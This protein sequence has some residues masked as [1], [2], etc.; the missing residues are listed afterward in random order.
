M[1]AGC[2]A[3]RVTA[4]LRYFAALA[5]AGVL[6]GCSAPQPPA[7]GDVEIMA[8]VVVPQRPGPA[9]T[10]VDFKQ[11]P[12]WAAEKHADAVAPFLA[13][14]GRMVGQSLGGTGEAARRAGAG[15]S[16]GAACAAAAA[17]P[18]GD[19][20]A[21]RAFFERYMQPWIASADGSA[22]GQFTGYYEPQL[23]GSSKRG[24]IYQTPLLRK[25][26]SQNLPGHNLPSRAQIVAGALAKQHLE[27]V[28][29]SDPIDA[30][31][32]EIQGAGRIHMT[33]GRDIRVSYDGQNGHGYFPIGRLLVERGE[34]ALPD[35]SLQSIRAWLIAHPKQAREV[36]NHNPSYV[37]FRE[38]PNTDPNRGPPGA[39]GAA[40]TPLR[41][42]AVDKS[43]VPMGTPVWIE[44]TDPV[45]AKP[46]RQLMMAQDV[47]GAIKG[48]V[49]AD[50]FF[51][52]G[53]PA[54][55]RAGLMNKPGAAY[56]LLPRDLGT[57]V[58]AK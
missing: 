15:T 38:L 56:L 48:P 35:V 36:M 8:G 16:W 6:A 42:I 7:P 53:P 54:E 58:A 21:A 41:S 12:G 22:K 9:L 40:L 50:I 34:M 28:W 49:R 25:P 10:A 43:F 33:D 46:I 19:D 24:G 2:R 5:L 4:P 27:L 37:F 45:T 23:Q 14:C 55:Q 1:A 17:L 47:G 31:F 20:A 44:T 29:V 18:P 11:L 57:S 51:G 30:F 3:Q 52:W 13:G 39:L 32:L 26:A